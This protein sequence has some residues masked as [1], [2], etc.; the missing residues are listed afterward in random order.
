[1]LALLLYALTAIATGVQLWY[2][3][4][5]AIWGAP[6]SPLQYVALFG[7]VVLLVAA[8]FARWKPR[9]AAIVACTGAFLLWFFY[10]PALYTLW[11]NPP[12]SFR[13]DTTPVVLLPMALLIVVTGYAGAR[14]LR[15]GRKI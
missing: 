1:V 9:I 13:F 2:L 7:S 15:T 5:W 3:L 10:G 6:T 4:S 14:A 8:V 11:H 12:L